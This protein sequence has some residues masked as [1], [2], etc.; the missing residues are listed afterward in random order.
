MPG[1][2]IRVYT[3][4]QGGSARSKGSDAIRCVYWATDLD[5]PFAKTRRIHRVE[6]WER[7][8]TNRLRIMAGVIV[9]MKPIACPKCGAPMHRVR[10]KG[11]YDFFS[12]LCYPECKGTRESDEVLD[13]LDETEDSVLAY[14]KESGKLAA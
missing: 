5:R 13:Y 11:E 10:K 8:L 6:N 12:C 3:S 9:Q 1:Y 4:I 7:N 14:L 2:G